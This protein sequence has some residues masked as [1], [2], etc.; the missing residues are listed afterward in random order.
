VDGGP[1]DD[2]IEAEDAAT[3]DCGT[4]NDTLVLDKAS[5]AQLRG[6]E[7]V[8]RPARLDL[9]SDP[10]GAPVNAGFVTGGPDAG[11]EGSLGALVLHLVRGTRGPDHLVGLD[12]P[13]ATQPDAD[14]IL[15]SDGNDTLVG[16]GGNDHLEGENGNDLLL[17]G[18]GDDQLF[19]RT[20]DDRLDGGPGRDTLE[21]GRGR[22]VLRGREGDDHLNGGLDADRIYGD[23]GDDIVIAVGGGPDRIDCGPGTDKVYVDSADTATNCE[24]VARSRQ[25]ILRTAAR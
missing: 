24:V 2:R 20:G 23:E 21:G 15:G 6:C 12:T 13:T 5:N 10:L 11:Q 7:Q 25:R 4:G 17:G 14:L 9:G 16:L 1:G 8:E 18:A 3:I 22:D 19:G